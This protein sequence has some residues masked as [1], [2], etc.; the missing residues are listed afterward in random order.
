MPGL[1][2]EVIKICHEKDILVIFDEVQCSIGRSWK[3]ICL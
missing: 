3:I 2:K 1:L